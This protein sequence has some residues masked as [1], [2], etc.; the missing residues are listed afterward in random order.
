MSAS[1]TSQSRVT[2]AIASVVSNRAW[3]WIAAIIVISV[4]G[5]FWLED[6][7]ADLLYRLMVYLPGVDKVLHVLQALVLMFVFHRL[8]SRLTGGGRAASWLAAAATITVSVIDE[9]QQ[10][11]QPGRSVELADLAAAASGTIIGVA[12]LHRSRRVWS[13]VAIAC[14]LLLAVAVTYR[15]YQATKGLT[16]A[17]RMESAGRLREARAAYQ[18]MVAAGPVTPEAYNSRAWAEIESGVGNA[19]AAVQYAE[20]L[21]EERPDDPNTLDTYGWALYHAGRTD[22]AR[23]QLTRAYE[24]NPQMNTIHYHLGM[25]ALAQGRASEARLHF[26]AQVL[27]V[28]KSRETERARA[29]LMTSPS[30]HIPTFPRS[31]ES[32]R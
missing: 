26:E 18:R 2:P 15:S 29:L 5:L 20:L 27:R 14:G 16:L 4:G 7:G 25:V 3:W 12:S 1:H 23:T 6:A 13:K 21:L 32:A 22:E 30:S 8:A 17:Q 28:P 10:M 11:W 31:H 24:L 19:E 9:L